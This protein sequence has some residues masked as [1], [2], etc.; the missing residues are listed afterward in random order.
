MKKKADIFLVPEENYEEALAVKKEKD[1]EI[2]IISVTTLQ[3]AID[4]ISK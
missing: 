4:E 1:S 2:R 3:Q